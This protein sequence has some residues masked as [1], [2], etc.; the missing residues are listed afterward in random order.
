MNIKMDELKLDVVDLPDNIVIR[1]ARSFDD[2]SRFTLEYIIKHIKE[3]PDERFKNLMYSF[4]SST[5]FYYGKRYSIYINKSYDINGVN[6]SKSDYVILL[7]ATC[8]Y[9]VD[10]YEYIEICRFTHTR[11]DSMKNQYIKVFKRI[12]Q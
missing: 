3:N 1:F 9:T 5:D 11:L 7:N 8:N 4:S 6:N 12:E 2:V 10:D